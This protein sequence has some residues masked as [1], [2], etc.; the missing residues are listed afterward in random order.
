MRRRNFIGLACGIAAAATSKPDAFPIIDSHVHLYD[1]SRP[2]GVP[3]PEPGQPI[4]RTFLPPD[5]RKI[6]QP[7]GVVGMLE[8]ECSPWV[9]DNDWVLEVA[10]RDTIV[11]GTIGNLYPGKPDF[12]EHLSRLHRN[13]LFR[14]IRF[15]Y[16]WGR[17]LAAESQKPEFLADL[18]VLAQSGLVLDS[19]GPPKLA[20]DV[21]RI[22]DKVPGLRIVID[23]LPGVEPPSEPAARDKYNRMLKEIAGRPQIYVK[24]SEVFRRVDP[25]GRTVASGGRIPRELA[26]YRPRLDQL[27]EVF[28][29]DRVLFGSDW[30]NSEPMATFAQ[31]VDL[32][33]EYFAPKGR[34]ATERFFW[35]NSVQAYRWIHRSPTQPQLPA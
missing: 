29:P 27:F 13:P 4:Y 20:A 30:T 5:Y 3:W 34:D 19:F 9:E 17:D 33:R 23:H 11:L 12:H 35:K 1:P 25:N 26:F 14:G 16:L 28:G 7:S 6:A 22:S 18:K 8:V 21:V 10:A 24:L 15:G 32:L 2:Q 31:T